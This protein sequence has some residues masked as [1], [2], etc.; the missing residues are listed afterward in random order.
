M[1]VHKLL[2]SNMLRP[3]KGG[4]QIRNLTPQYHLF[5]HLTAKVIRA[6]YFISVYFI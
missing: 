2:L 6:S 4:E 1:H 3:G 5:F